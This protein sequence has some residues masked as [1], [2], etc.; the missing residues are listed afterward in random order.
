[1]PVLQGTVIFTT[2][3]VIVGNFIADILYSVLDPR[4]RKA[5]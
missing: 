1:M 3:I 5:A 2:V 4:I